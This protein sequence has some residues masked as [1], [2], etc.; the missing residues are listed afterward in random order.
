[1][2]LEELVLED[3]KKEL[4]NLKFKKN[5]NMVWKSFPYNE[6]NL[7][8]IKVAINS[9]SKRDNEYRLT[10]DENVIFVEKDIWP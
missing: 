1:M 10:Y 7:E 4:K 9:I 2:K 5:Q 6:K 8:T 3:V